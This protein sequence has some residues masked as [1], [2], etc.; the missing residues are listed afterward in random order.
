MLGWS[1]EG[2]G[3]YNLYSHFKGYLDE[4]RIYNRALTETEI[5]ELYNQC[6]NYA[7]IWKPP[8]QYMDQTT[9]YAY[10]MQDGSTLPIKFVVFGPNGEFY[11]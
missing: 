6:C 1:E 10:T 7:L 5:P 4:V 8:I 3:P 9:T 2:A 11:V